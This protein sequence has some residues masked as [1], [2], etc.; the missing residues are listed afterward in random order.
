[1]PFILLF[2][3]A[4]SAAPAAEECAQ[5]HAL[6]SDSSH[7]LHTASGIV[8]P[9]YGDTGITR[10]YVQSSRT[11]GYNCGNCHPDDRTMHGNGSVDVHLFSPGASGLKR[12]NSPAASYDRAAKTCSGVYCHSSGAGDFRESP[13]WGS[14]F[15]EARCQSC[16]GSPPEYASRKGKENSH[17]N[18]T[19]G[20]GHLLGIHWDAT[21]GHTK[22][23]FANR[24]SSDMGCS[25]C[26]Y[27]TVAADRD[28]TFVDPVRGLFTCGRCHDGSAVAGKNRSGIITNT[29]LHVNGTV[30][31][32]FSPE[33]FRTTAQLMR[34]PDGWKRIGTKWE[35]KS[36]D[37]TIRE[38]NTAQYLPAEK[39]CLNVACHL[40]GKEVRWGDAVDCDACHQDI[41][42]G[43]P[44]TSRQ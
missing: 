34:V 27:D 18:I 20:S 31:V 1:M 38:L 9:R 32:S 30:E 8:T 5:C 2:F 25:T 36:Y 11:Y 35:P 37:E 19:R 22:E 14:S 17:F 16:H 29:A 33:K 26:H 40:M 6:P 41:G 21:G 10:Q 15:T 44:D 12:R 3:L 28:T 13:A 24:S 42:R 39:K 4:A 7:A 43:K 23:S